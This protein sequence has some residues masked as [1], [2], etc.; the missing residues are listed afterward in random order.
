MSAFF[1]VLKWVSLIGVV[2]PMAVLLLLMNG[3]LLAA[4]VLGQNPNFLEWMA[5]TGLLLSTGIAVG[6]ATALWDAAK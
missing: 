4:F 1:S 5:W 3:Y 2:L 6:L